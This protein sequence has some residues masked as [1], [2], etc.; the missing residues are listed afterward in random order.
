GV[1]DLSGLATVVGPRT[2]GVFAL[3]D[4]ERLWFVAEGMVDLFG[5]GQD[6][7]GRWQFLCR[8]GAGPV[9][10]GPVAPGPGIHGK[11]LP[12]GAV[13]SARL[14]D[15]LAAVL[16]GAIPDPRI[17]RPRNRVAEQLADGIDIWFGAL[18]NALRVDLPPR[19]FVALEADKGAEIPAG[20]T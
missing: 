2:D 12:G 16:P 17:E 4:P 7:G 5:A 10:G 11:P 13:R 3:D 18:A 9:L 6:D 1:M 15:A 14:D 19:D 8:V 20:G